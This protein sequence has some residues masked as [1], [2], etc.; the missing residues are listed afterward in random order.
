MRYLR[1]ASLL[2]FLTSY[3]AG[4]FCQPCTNGYSSVIYR[5]ISWD[6]FT[7]ALATPAGEWV[8]TGNILDDH[9]HMAKF[10]PKGTPLFSYQYNPVYEFNTTYF[11]HLRF[12]DLI[13]TQDGSFITAGNVIVD[14]WVGPYEYLNKGGAVVKTD[15]YG[16]VIW[17]KKFQTT[18]GLTN[19]GYHLSATNVAET[20]TGD[21]IAYVASDFGANY[22]AHGRLLCLSKG[23]QRKWMTIL[24]TNY[25][26]GGLKSLQTKRALLTKR[27]GDVVLGDVLYKT[28]RTT[29]KTIDVQLHFLGFDANTGKIQWEQWYRY[30]MAEK[31]F[32]PDFTSAVELSDGNLAFTLS[33]F[34][35]ANGS[36]GVRLVTTNKGKLLTAFTYHIGQTSASS[37]VSS[38][39]D[40]ATG[41]PSYLL[42]SN[43]HSLIAAIANDGSV[44]WQKAYS[45]R[46]NLFP[47]SCLSSFSDGFGVFMSSMRNWQMR[48]LITN[49]NGNSG[50]ADT[51]GTIQ[52]TQVS[53]AEGE[54][55]VT[56]TNVTD[57]P[58]FYIS[59]FPLKETSNP[60]LV[61][62]ECKENISC[63]R[64]I[65]DSTNLQTTFICEGS[66]YR[67]PNGVTVQ[68]SGTYYAVYK[69]N[70]GC[71]SIVYH[72]VSVDKKLAD[73]T[74]GDDR[75]MDGNDSLLL[76]AT[77][78]YQQYAWSNNSINSS[79]HLAIRKAGTYWV[80]VTNSCGSKTDSVI[81]HDLCDF[82]IY[83]SDAFTPNGDGRNDVF[84]VSPLNKNRF[85]SLRI[86][87]RWGQLIYLTN[88]MNKGW[89]GTYSHVPQPTGVYIY[90]VEMMGLSGK[91]LTK[92]GT[93]LLIR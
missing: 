4:L 27:N 78:G 38:A 47:A 56:V 37:I 29:G 45:H 65:I 66:S 93:V 61:N 34:P 22:F 63:C 13:H 15:S 58:G 7:K 74:L 86:F 48:L 88:T 19:S 16:H 51:T 54:S 12:T 80:N 5:S 40:Y 39:T 32:Y 52:I 55:I 11:K 76:T 71:D 21:I 92:S 41:L 79:P 68:R 83:M 60:L 23:G 53:L 31:Y 73:L 46:A 2:F 8:A 50:C 64:D 90:F 20:C 62:I 14:R 85:V 9:G 1:M 33:T 59:D 35:T 42:T 10:S 89:N 26:D 3:D 49:K 25:Y 77:D 43:S 87:N 72:R 81:V 6:T 67:L 91:K 28:D 30:P 17:S 36:K 69:T 84:G 18:I 57:P 24:G 82:P 44:S 75:C 70:G